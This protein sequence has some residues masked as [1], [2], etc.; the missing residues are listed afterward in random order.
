[1]KT[2]TNKTKRCFW[3]ALKRCLLFVFRESQFQIMTKSFKY[4]KIILY[5]SE[6]KQHEQKEKRSHL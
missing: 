1:M 6:V 5:K 3:K 2:G 4:G